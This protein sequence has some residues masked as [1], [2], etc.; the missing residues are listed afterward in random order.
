MEGDMHLEVLV[1]QT[2]RSVSGSLPRATDAKG[3]KGGS[4]IKINKC[5]P[6]LHIHVFPFLKYLVSNLEVT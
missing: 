2:L 1:I 4:D 3:T 5:Q 6:S